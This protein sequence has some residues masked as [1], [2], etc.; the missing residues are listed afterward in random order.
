MSDLK[1]RRVRRTFTHN[2]TV[3]PEEVFPLLCPV[4]EYDWIPHWECQLVHSESGVA[5][6]DCIFRTSFPQLGESVWSVSCYE[7]PRRIE[8]VVVTVATHVER[9]EIQV[10]PLNGGGSTL[11][12]SRTYTGLNEQGNALVEHF[13]SGPLDERMEQVMRMLEHYCRTGEMLRPKEA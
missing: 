12:W 1:A 8:F 6:K 7:P 9:L 4:R 11:R 10:D 5:E 2:V 13:S 3:P